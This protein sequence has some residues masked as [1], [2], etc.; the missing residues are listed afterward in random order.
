MTGTGATGRAAARATPAA[1]PSRQR[2]AD[3][4][5]HRSAD[6]GRADRTTNPVSLHL[7]ARVSTPTDA[8][9]IAADR[10]AAAATERGPRGA[11]RAHLGGAGGGPAVHRSCAACAAGGGGG[12][13]ERRIARR[14]AG[15]G[16][17]ALTGAATA[18]GPPERA[19]I[20]VAAQTGQ[21]LPDDLRTHMEHAFDADFGAVRLHTDARAA[22]AARA[23]D[24][25]AFTVGNHVAF[26]AGRFEP[27][28]ERG[29]QLVAH[30]LAHVVQQGAG[31][32]ASARAPPATI[33]RAEGG[34][35]TTRAGAFVSGL[36]SDVG[37]GVTGIVTDVRQGVTDVV[38]DVGHG[39]ESAASFT[40][41]QLV[42]FVE[43][44]AP[45]VLAF[46]SGDYLQPLT[47]ALAGAA[48]GRF[49]PLMAAFTCG[50]VKEGPNE[51]GT[52]AG[53]GCTAFASAAVGAIRAFGRIVV[54]PMLDCGK[55]YL[56]A[57][58][59]VLSA[60]WDLLAKPAIDFVRESA[61]YR[62]I[63]E[64]VT[65]LWDS[66]KELREWS[67]AVSLA[68][69]F[70]FPLLSKLGVTDWL[71]D[72]ATAAWD[73]VKDDVT[74]WLPALKTA[75]IVLAV[76]SGFGPLL[77]FLAVAPDLWSWL[78]WLV[79][80]WASGEIVVKA[81][82]A[83]MTTVIPTVLGGIATAGAGLR[84]AAATVGAV[85]DG[86]AAALEDLANQ[87]G[88][89]L[90]S[91]A[92]GAVRYVADEAT[93]FAATVKNGLD[94]ALGDIE[95]GLQGVAE[96]LL[97]IL[98]VVQ[99][100][101]MVMANPLAPFL[102]T[103]GALWQLLP[104]CIKGPI[105]DLFLDL[106]LAVVQAGPPFEELRDGWGPVATR[107][108]EKITEVKALSVEDRVALSNTIARNLVEGG[109]MDIIATAIRA[110]IR[111]PERF[112]GQMEKELIG[113]D[114]TKPL[115]FERSA[116]AGGG[117]AGG[118]GSP[119]QTLQ[120]L[121]AG[122]LGEGDIALTE[123]AEF[124]LDDAS[125]M[126]L[127]TADT[128]IELPGAGGTGATHGISHA[129]L[130]AVLGSGAGGVSTLAPPGAA[131]GEPSLSSL[132]PEEQLAHLMA[133]PVPSPCAQPGAGAGAGGGGP[134]AGGPGAGGE[135]A[136]GCPPMPEGEKLGP[137]TQAQRAQYVLTQ[138]RKGIGAWWDCNKGWLIPAIV[139]ALLVLAVVVILTEGAALEV[140]G[141][142]MEIIGAILLG[143]SIVRAGL[144]IGMYGV[145]SVTGDVDLAADSLARALAIIAIE[146]V[147]LL[148]FDIGDIVKGFKGGFESGMKAVGT[149]IVKPFKQAAKAVGSI[150]ETSLKALTTA[151]KNLKAAGRFGMELLEDGRLLLRGLG[152]ELRG[153][154]RSIEEL[155]T[156][157]KQHPLFEK[158]ELWLDDFQA[159]LCGVF[160]P[161][162]RCA[163]GR[164]NAEQLKMMQ[165]VR[166][167]KLSAEEVGH[168]AG[169]AE[170]QLQGLTKAQRARFQALFGQLSPVEQDA[171]LQALEKGLAHPTDPP[172]HLWG[173]MTEQ[174]NLKYAASSGQHIL[175][176]PGKVSAT[177][178]DMV[179]FKDG[180]IVVW[181]GKHRLSGRFPSDITVKQ[182]NAWRPEIRRAAFDEV[183]RLRQVG[184]KANLALAD[185]IEQALARPGMQCCDFKVFPW[186]RSGP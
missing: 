122:T 59:A 154:T 118:A 120:R 21:P 161:C 36:A 103:A 65:W 105:I 185:Q 23:I 131:E 183:A 91:I 129:D 4:A 42:A 25:H 182:W 163:V 80:N 112:V 168:L 57:A 58:G 47:S 38:T 143:W 56:A 119:T 72:Q 93:S 142:I 145:Y 51:Q 15:G 113:Q 22:S 35:W 1:A 157:L 39:V 144:F 147:F 133:Q 84:T 167:M 150:G 71:M 149:S 12:C 48:D 61:A 5:V 13:C 63:T 73:S 95:A 141:Q 46:V 136:A 162:K 140:I 130:A 96:V 97:T 160:N 26:A 109:G 127:A 124:G 52:A 66:T 156:A 53:D 126:R 121:A 43:A 107:I 45:G 164:P 16:A 27:Q 176:P 92:A 88:G 89:G 166:A 50:Q 152:A 108:T 7:F 104:D 181:D 171:L 101:T 14:A 155:G 3:R 64:K 83:L 98:E 33:H 100:V 111:A 32:P 68:P 74:P 179:T 86:A 135:H 180:N 110:A 29:R 85:L 106:I 174:L 132:P 138:M 77:L 8:H 158:Y 94:A 139:A 41:D 49:A 30:E 123:T 178:P 2:S 75:G 69:I 40:R 78:T 99:Q 134:P 37:Q 169:R 31:T 9:E 116:V 170:K 87:L 17:A 18:R 19:A 67:L 60:A 177:G 184:G 165:D 6:R 146:L 186:T 55:A 90:L 62:W 10:A 114:L 102:M 28:T 11:A 115:C 173:A 82:E 44:H 34:G 117:A 175:Q 172:G 137:F 20:D 153:G 151:V 54:D 128:R 76:L 24:A 148:I 81:R 125:W 70:P 159:M 79:D